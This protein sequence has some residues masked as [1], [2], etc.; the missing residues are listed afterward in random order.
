MSKPPV[1]F[2][3]ALRSQIVAAAAAPQRNVRRSLRRAVGIA[4]IPT[5]V[6]TVIIVRSL[7]DA[8]SSRVDIE[9]AEPDEPE[10]TQRGEVD[11]TAPAATEPEEIER[12][13]PPDDTDID[14]SVL[15]SPSPLDTTLV[16]L[17]KPPV[18][19]AGD[20]VLVVDFANGQG[21]VQV[22]V[23]GP[24]VAP[25][26][27]PSGMRNRQNPGVV[28]TPLGLVIAGG[29]S[30]Q[31][32][33]EGDGPFGMLFD[34]ATSES[35]EIPAPPSALR[36][37]SLATNRAVWV[38]G[39]VVFWQ[40]GFALDPTTLEWSEIAQG[41]RAS[42]SDFA[43]AHAIGGRVIVFGGCERDADSDP[44]YSANCRETGANP[45]NDGA[46]YD[47]A[48]NSWT[49]LAP[50]PLSGGAHHLAAI[51]GDTL[52]VL[53][54][55]SAELELASYNADTDAWQV[56]RPPALEPRV[57]AAIAAFGDGL[58]VFGGVAAADPSG[59]TVLADGGWYDAAG[60]V[61]QLFRL[62][63]AWARSHHSVVETPDDELYVSGSYT[64]NAPFDLA[65]RTS[66]N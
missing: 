3:A 55:E 31:Q 61:W 54:A 52:V 63:Q 27:W 12:T 21:E 26:V 39:Q 16:D 57:H 59:L 56:L 36:A 24:A 34:P 38:S 23:H 46:L 28:M 53:N 42:R 47:P 62:P 11:D 64:N 4:L 7:D 60:D 51:V 58:V 2:E 15:F 29:Q 10:S 32:D 50:A 65:L 6:A 22:E 1:D 33:A 5:V 17:V 40:D 19:A 9:T 48:S 8:E 14:T 25:T 44:E 35:L 49:D 66:T 13:T 43:S 37:F 45:R 41:P 18:V 30:N 20:L